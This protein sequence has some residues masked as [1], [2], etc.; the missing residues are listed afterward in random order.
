M[1]GKIKGAHRFCEGVWATGAG[2]WHIRKLGPKGECL[3]GGIDT[4][5]LCGH[6][7]VGQGWDL[8]VEI[9]DHHL[10]HACKKCV[11]LYRK[12]QK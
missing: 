7:R 11:E 5:S 2:P 12:D 1:R 4:E 10:G 3:G 9:T 8:S 6:V